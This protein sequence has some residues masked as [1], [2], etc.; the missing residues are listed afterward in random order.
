MTDQTI[1]ADKVRK[2]ASEMRDAMRREDDGYPYVEFLSDMGDYIRDLEALL[3][4]PPLPTLADMTLDERDECRWMQADVKGY[5]SRVVLIN[6]YWKDGRARVLR[7]G[8]FIDQA[9]WEQVT[10][11][12]DLPRLEWPGDT[13]APAPETLTEG[14]EWGDIDALTTACRESGRDQI[15]VADTDG[16]V[17]VW[18]AGAEW[19]ESG[20]PLAVDAPY[21]IIHT[22]KAGQ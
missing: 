9:D 22:G 12:P 17:F 10:P 7:P 11:R 19:W 15:T 18:G 1:P 6:P 14:S 3:P 21:T 20:C 4:A 2:I 8:A 5:E 13:P 16:D